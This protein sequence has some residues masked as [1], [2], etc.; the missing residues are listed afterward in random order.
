MEG[1][2]PFPSPWGPLTS[3]L[4]PVLQPGLVSLW[5]PVDHG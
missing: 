3:S 2:G 1:P 5:E 4:I